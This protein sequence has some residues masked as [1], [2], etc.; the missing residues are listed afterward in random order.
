MPALPRYTPDPSA[1]SAGNASAG[2]NSAPE[3]CAPA[4]GVRYGAM[5]WIGEFR[6]PAQVIPKCGTKLV[7][8]SERGIELGEQVDLLCRGREPLVDRTQVRSYVDSSGSEFYRF[9]AGK[10]LREASAQDINEH[11][12]LN[13]H[14][15]ADVQRCAG[16]ASELELDL[17]V[18]TA[19]HLLGGERIVFY[20]RSEG[21]IDFRDLVRG[22][23]QHYQTR[24]E[25]RQ[26]GARDEARLIADYEICGRQ[27]CCKNFLKKLRP[28]TMR[29]AKL[30]KSTLDPSKVSGR[31]GRLRCCLR[32]EH[33]GYDELVRKL[34]RLGARLE[35]EIGPATVIDRQV[36][37]QL[38]LVR[39]DDD[40][41][42]A[43][44]VNETAPL[45]TA[46]PRPAA[47]EPEPLASRFEPDEP[48]EAD[49]KSKPEEK[50]EEGPR[51][52]RRSRR[53]PKPTENSDQTA[54]APTPP[55]PS[56]RSPE[57]DRPPE[58][59]S[60]DTT[61][62]EGK[63]RPPRKRRRRRRRPRRGQSDSTPGT[64]ES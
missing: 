35:T 7:I 41:T 13:E 40:R 18:I 10:V 30:Q 5:S 51:R 34:P 9:R 46:P 28:V 45:G 24:I 17:K 14:V 60:K 37:T 53:R 63:D 2:H 58:A 50:P 59:P 23:A 26:V 43:V 57:A 12:R 16:L 54:E 62:S 25:M 4:C 33:E 27:C 55:A 47:R 56:A 38:L 64:D 39:G 48:A 15:R 11:A 61:G 42:L 44:P 29:M 3:S 32:Y 6:L 49:S 8:E 31:C 22:L 20:F 1:D 52:R 19:E 36:L 21:R